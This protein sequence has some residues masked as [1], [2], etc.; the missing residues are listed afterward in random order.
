V[1]GCLRLQYLFNGDYV[2]R[3]G[4]GVEICI[5]LFMFAL[6]DPASVILNRGNHEERSQNEIGVRAS[7]RVHVHACATPPNPQTPC[8][9]LVFLQV[10]ASPAAPLPALP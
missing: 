8:L 10:C 7:R 9:P 3:G 5:T 6:L 1:H 4:Y 2:D